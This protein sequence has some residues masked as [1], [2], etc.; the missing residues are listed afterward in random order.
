MARDSVN[1]WKNFAEEAGGDASFVKSGIDFFTGEKDR[2]LPRKTCVSESAS[3]KA[4]FRA[5]N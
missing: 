5:G 2:D 1:V 4:F 3:A